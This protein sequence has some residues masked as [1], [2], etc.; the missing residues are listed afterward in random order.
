MGNFPYRV[1]KGKSS[2]LLIIKPLLQELILKLDNPLLWT[3]RHSEPLGLLLSRVLPSIL[4]Q[5]DNF[6]PFLKIDC[7]GGCKLDIVGI[8][9]FVTV[10]GGFKGLVG[11]Y[12]LEEA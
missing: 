1:E 2:N 3:R 12:G 4:H 8:A 6:D 7:L 5:V 11:P 9:Q 10:V